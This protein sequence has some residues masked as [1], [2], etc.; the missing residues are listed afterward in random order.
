MSTT[1]PMPETLARLPHHLA[2]HFPTAERF[3]GVCRTDHIE[4]LSSRGLLDHVRDVALGFETLGV[5]PGAR[6]ALLAESRPE[7][8]VCDLA[9]LMLGAVAVPIYPTLSSVQVEALL[10][11]SGCVVAIASTPE[12][13]AKVLAV[14]PRLAQLTAAVT[15]GAA[16]T[17]AFPVHPLDDIAA[18]GRA[19][20]QADPDAHARLRRVADAVRADDLATIIYTSGSSG[21]PKGVMLTHGNIAANLRDVPFVLTLSDHD[22]ALSYL[23]LC[24]AFER[25]VVYVY[26]TH[27]VSVV[28]AESI[29]SMARDLLLVR[30]TVMSGVPRVYEKLLDRILDGGHAEHGVRRALFEL[31]MRVARERGRTVPDGRPMALWARLALPLV[32]AIV[33]RTILGRLGGRLRF[34]VSGS[35]PLREEVGRLFF[36]IGMPIAEGYGL[37]ETAPVLTVNRPE[38][39]RFGTVGPPLPSVQLRIADDGEILAK[40][41]NIMLGYYGRPDLTAQAIVDGWFHTGDIGVID[42]LGN[43]KITDRKKELLV[44]SGGKK[45][46]PQPIEAALRGQGVIAEAIVI[47]DRQRFPAALVLPRWAALAAAVGVAAPTDVASRRALAD[48]ADARARVQAAI[49]TVNEPLAQ[50]ERLKAFEILLEDF[51]VQSG[52]LT[53]TFKVKRRVIEERYAALIARM[54]S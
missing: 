32:R 43:L 6:V 24:H 20:A 39:L 38:A 1:R 48:R 26:L 14:Q 18:R 9:I 52:E 8:I 17:A 34:T 22:V 50:Y 21:E 40:G 15:F 42:A 53:P 13:V 11:D 5:A 45:V 10:A 7:W 29:D 37:T 44:T 35:A 36:G 49:D 23:P 33:F 25:T 27:G 46:A 12:Q 51:G 41:P 19:C 31:G 54:Y 4:Y 30:P 3:L 47:G 28:F 2:E 16:T